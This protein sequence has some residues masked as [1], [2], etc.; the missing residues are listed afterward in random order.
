MV[1][2]DSATTLS[3]HSLGPRTPPTRTA[4]RGTVIC[5]QPLYVYS[6]YMCSADWCDSRP[7]CTVQPVATRG[8]YHE[9]AHGATVENCFVSFQF[10]RH[11]TTRPALTTH[12]VWFVSGSANTTY[13]VPDHIRIDVSYIHR[14]RPVR[15]PSR[16]TEHSGKSERERRSGGTDR[17]GRPAGTLVARSVP[18]PIAWAMAYTHTRLHPIRRSRRCRY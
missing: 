16:N 5:E 18:R 15:P 4:S 8:S 10:R 3:R 17:A 7:W 11:P 2:F 9:P 1:A 14:T 13:A 12:N 6:R